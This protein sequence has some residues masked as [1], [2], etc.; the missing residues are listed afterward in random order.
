MRRQGTSGADS[1]NRSAARNRGPVRFRDGNDWKEVDLDLAQEEAEIAPAVS[2]AGVAFPTDPDEGVAVH[3]S[4][5]GPI[6]VGLPSVLSGP[7][8]GEIREGSGYVPDTV[9]IEG[10]R[11]VDSVVTR[12]SFGFELT[13]GR[14]DVLGE[15]AGSDPVSLRAGLCGWCVVQ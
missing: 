3:D 14:E 12:L 13:A 11:G 9:V 5:A 2:D 6:T 10:A 1:D 4:A 15:P 8:E 7:A